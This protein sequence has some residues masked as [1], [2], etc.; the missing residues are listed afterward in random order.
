MPI[1]KKHSL[2]HKN[3]EGMSAMAALA[4]NKTR[5]SQFVCKNDQYE[6]NFRE[7]FQAPFKL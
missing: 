6:W 1:P 5:G 4:N 2:Y 3:V 7:S